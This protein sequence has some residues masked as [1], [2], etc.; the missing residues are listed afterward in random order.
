MV[1]RDQSPCITK[2]A[3][4]ADVVV[5]SGWPVKIGFSRACVS[6]GGARCK[7]TARRLLLDDGDAWTLNAS[8][9]RLSSSRK[10]SKRRILG[11][12]ARATFRPPIEN[13]TRCLPI[14]LGSGCG[15]ILAS[16]ADMSLLNH[17]DSAKL[18]ADPLQSREGRRQDG[19]LRLSDACRKCE[20]CR[21]DPRGS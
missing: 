21:R 10:C 1:D 16:A 13:M 5:F 8:L 20:A 11:H 6:G 7:L 15:S 17:P 2:R 19:S 4:R 3:G 12:S 18:K 14:A 9:T